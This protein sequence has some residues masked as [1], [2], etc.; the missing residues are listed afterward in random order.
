MTYLLTVFSL[1]ERE[2]DHSG[3]GCFVLFCF[4]NKG[5]NTIY[6]VSTLMT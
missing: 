4:F 2:R 6:E 1:K 3:G 5:S